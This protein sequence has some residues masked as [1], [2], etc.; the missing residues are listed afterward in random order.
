MSRQLGPRLPMSHLP[1][2]PAAAWRRGSGPVPVASLSPG[3]SSRTVSLRASSP[4]SRGCRACLLAVGS[5]CR[6]L[7]APGLS[8]SW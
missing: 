2:G 3:H 6:G 8:N 5:A 7:C 4:L 1:R